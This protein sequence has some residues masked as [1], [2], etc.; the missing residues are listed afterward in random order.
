[1][2]M[3]IGFI[4][5]SGC[6]KSTLARYVSEKYG[7]PICPVGSR[8]VAAAMGFSNP[9]DVD[10][11]GRRPEFQRRLFEE[12]RAWELEHESFVSDRTYFDNLIYAIMHGCTQYMV[13][14][15]LVEYATAMKRYSLVIHCPLAAFQNLGDDPARIVSKTYH[16][17]YE[18]MTTKLIYDSLHIDLEGLEVASLLADRDRRDQVDQFIGELQF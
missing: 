14:G 15:E 2:T 17:V 4:G 16:Q 7:L 18:F 9:Y 11:A 1:M 10:K 8:S 12:K 3:R 6:G 13:D 5:C